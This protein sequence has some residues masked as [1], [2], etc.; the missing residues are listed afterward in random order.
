METVARWQIA[1]NTDNKPLE[2]KN[3]CKTFHF[4]T[5]GFTPKNPKSR[6]RVFKHPVV[7][8]SV[9]LN[10]CDTCWTGGRAC[11]VVSYSKRVNLLNRCTKAELCWGV[12][13]K[14]STTEHNLLFSSSAYFFVIHLILWIR[15]HHFQE[16]YPTTGFYFENIQRK[17]SWALLNWQLIRSTSS[18]C[19]GS[20]SGLIASFSGVMSDPLLHPARES[21][22]G[23]HW[24]DFRGR[25]LQRGRTRVTCKRRSGRCT[26]TAPLREVSPRPRCCG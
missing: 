17:S 11:A 2:W 14:T 8:F 26:A 19:S 13:C 21:W 9:A 25:E 5:S 15:G 12:L 3:W 4:I 1:E 16:V 24:G 23:A 18:C 6:K 7:A 10:D 20:R 22:S